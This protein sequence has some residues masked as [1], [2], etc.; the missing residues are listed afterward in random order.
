MW[1]TWGIK[2]EPEKLG[3]CLRSLPSLLADVGRRSFAGEFANSVFQFV[4]RSDHSFRESLTVGGSVKTEVPAAP[5]Q[6][7]AARAVIP[8]VAEGV[9]C[10]GGNCWCWV[11]R[12]NTG[13][14]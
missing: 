2:E 4:F 8:A 12:A 14:W 9:P 3:G 5:E 1:K 11:R 7:T 6:V 13:M 10:A